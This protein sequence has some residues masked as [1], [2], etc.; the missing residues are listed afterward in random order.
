LCIAV[1][2][3]LILLPLGGAVVGYSHGGSSGGWIG[4]AG[5]LVLALV[6]V[7]LPTLI[8]LSAEKKKYDRE[9]ARR[10]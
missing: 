7:G 10:S 6:L 4:A 2:L 9:E 3:A 8:F 1:V 5:G